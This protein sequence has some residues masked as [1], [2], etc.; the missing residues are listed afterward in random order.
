MLALEQLRHDLDTFL[1]DEARRERPRIGRFE[2]VAR[3]AEK[4]DR[5]H[6]SGQTNLSPPLQRLDLALE[7]LYRDGVALAC[8]TRL[9]YLCH[10]LIRPYGKDQRQLI[11][12]ANRFPQV[13]RQIESR[14]HAQT[15]SIHW[16]HGLLDTYFQFSGEMDSHS[17]SNWRDLRAFLGRTLAIQ[18]QTVKHR[19]QKWLDALVEHRNLLTD[20]PCGRYATAALNENLAEVDSLREHLRIPEQSWFWMDLLRA[21]GRALT[22]LNDEIFHKLLDG[23]L[24][25]MGD[26]RRIPDVFATLLTR[27]YRSQF[28]NTAHP[29]LQ[30]VALKT[31]G[32]PNLG[33]NIRWG[34]VEDFVRQM[35]LRWLSR[36]DIQDF[37]RLLLQDKI[38]DKRRL[39]F[40]MRYA[41]SIQETHIALGKRAL[42]H[43]PD[44]VEMRKRK[45]GRVSILDGSNLENNA[46][47]MSFGKYI[48]VEFGGKGNA[49]YIYAASD[50][51]MPEHSQLK[52]GSIPE[53]KIPI[54]SIKDRSKAENRLSHTMDWEERFEQELERLGIYPSIQHTEMMSKEVRLQV[55]A[56]ESYEDTERQQKRE[57]VTPQIKLNESKEESSYCSNKTEPLIHGRYRDHGDGTVTDIKTGL[58]WKRCAEGQTWNGTTCVGEAKKYAWKDLPSDDGWRPPTIEELKTLIYCNNT[59]EFGTKCQGDYK[60]PTIDHEVFPNTDKS[61]FW[62]GSPVSGNSNDAWNVNFATGNVSW[63]FR[64]NTFSVRLARGGSDF[65]I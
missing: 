59:G 5:R 43:D 34:H 32:S 21:Q 31:W 58:R 2:E 48:V 64:Y 26:P 60:S 53:N 55:D 7:V 13:L 30:R 41:D 36:E 16:W 49:C 46:F 19:P 50:L 52:Y 57:I 1:Q 51:Q 45:L 17:Q 54:R 28:K 33:R 24:N 38:G 15:L 25:R 27:Y 6:G 22:S 63:L 61:Y 42:G 35:V 37:F 29:S 39:N 18:T 14:I 12:D 9:R 23:F 47:I 3:L 65:A 10:A 44:Y 62:S 4:L 20:D 8:E 40:W 56:K 11:A